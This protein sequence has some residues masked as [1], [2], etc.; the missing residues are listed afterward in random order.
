MLGDL[1]LNTLTFVKTE[2]DS[3]TGSKWK[4]TSRGVNLPENLTLRSQPYVDS[5]TKKSGI[6]TQLFL[7]RIVTLADTT[8]GGPSVSLVVRVPSDSGVVASDVASLITRLVNLLHGTSNTLGLDLKDE[9]FND[10]QK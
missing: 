9:I 10:G 2:A 1:T 4:E 8:L 5:K 3:Q 6:Q 7:E